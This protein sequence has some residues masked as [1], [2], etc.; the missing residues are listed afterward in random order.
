MC[1]GLLPTERVLRA[2]ATGTGN[3]LVLYGALTG[4]DGIGGASR[5]SRARTSR[6]PT[7]SGRRCRSAIPF[8]GKALI[9]VSLDLVER[10]LVLGLQDCGAAGLASSL[11]EM[12]RRRRRRRRPPRPRAAPRARPRAV[13]DHDLRVAGADGR[14][15]RA[16]PAR[17]GR[18]ARL[19]ALGAAVHRD[20]RGHRPRRAARLL[21]RRGRRRDP[22][23]A[24]H[25]RV[26]ALRARAGARP[27]PRRDSVRTRRAT[28]R[29]PGS[30]SSTTSS[31][32]RAR[33]AGPGS[34]R[35][36]CGSTATRGIAVSLDGPPLGE[37]DPFRAGWAAV[38]ERALNVACAGGEPLALTDCLNFGNPERAEIAWELARAIDGIAAAAQR[39]RHPGRLR[40]RLALQRDRRPADPADAG[41][42]LRRPRPRRDPHPVALA[43]RR[44]RR[45]SSAARAPT[46]SASSGRTRTASRSPT[47]S[48]T[49]GSRSRVAEAAA[50]SERTRR[51]SS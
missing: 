49:A 27:E 8:R 47:T 48:P 20:R 16:R 22:R 38:M 41:R 42:R 43:A 40:Q 39:A 15:R 33:C 14:G 18:G 51:G 46:S 23:R 37:R 7:R 36:C 10:D 44:P 30:S 26:P 2:K 50:W 24:A 34:T 12:A 21:R 17:R 11:A 3:L 6:A 35:R 45:R 32:A 5:C 9:E 1:V 19:R 25:R 4:R 13:G 29:R 28:S 31:S